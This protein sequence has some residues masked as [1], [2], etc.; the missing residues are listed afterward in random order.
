MVASTPWLLYLDDQ[1]C[2]AR[3][4]ASWFGR[5][6]VIVEGRP[7]IF[8]VNHLW[9]AGTRS[10][11]FPTGPGTKLASALEWP[12]VAYEIDGIDEAAM[13]GWSVLVVGRA[14]YVESLDERRRFVEERRGLWKA[15]AD[16]S[17]VRILPSRISGRQLGSS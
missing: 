1:E 7:E 15:G 6:A 2:E 4:A 3:L 12:W 16:D 5:L 17:W 10:I 11:V 14:E 13:T 9:D 8:P